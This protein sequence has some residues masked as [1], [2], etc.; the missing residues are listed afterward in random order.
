MYFSPNISWKYKVWLLAL[1]LY[2][3]LYLIDTKSQFMEIQEKLK[4]SWKKVTPERV[5][6]YAW[7]KNRHLFSAA[8]IQKDFSHIGRASIFRS[9]KLFCEIW[10]LRKV[11]LWESAESYEVECCADCRHE[12]MKCTICGN[13]VNFTSDIISGQIFAQAKKLGFHI[14][15]HSLSVF[16]T[17][18][19]CI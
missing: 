5:E 13:I 15:E 7:M 17:C 6:L 9:L 14:D 12:H 8:D 11:N 10:A 19:K 18:K 3:F 1:V 2:I 16:G 4:D